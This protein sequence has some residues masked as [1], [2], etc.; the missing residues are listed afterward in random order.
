MN[1][2]QFDRQAQ[3]EARRVVA[4]GTE[5]IRSAALQLYSDLSTDSRT[6]GGGYGSPVASGRLAG[7]MRLSVGSIDNTTAPADPDYR[8]PP[9]SGPREL[10]PRTVRN[11]P[12]S[13]VAAA[14]RGF[15]LGQTIFL[16]NSVPYIRKIEIGGHSWQTPEGVFEPTVRRW[17]RMFRHPLVRM[18]NG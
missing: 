10:P 7:S 17:L 5:A 1:L 16:S 4:Q 11:V 3:A 2:S 14:L 15:Q 18:R 12:I 13:R 6:V 8:Y 9:G